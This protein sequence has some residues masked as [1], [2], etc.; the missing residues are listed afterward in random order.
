MSR[1]AAA[2]LVDALRHPDPALPANAIRSTAFDHPSDSSQVITSWKVAEH[3]YRSHTTLLPTLARGLFTTGEPGKEIIVGRGYDKFFNVDE[4]AYT[5]VRL[6]FPSPTLRFSS[7]HVAAWE[8][9]C[10]PQ[11]I[12]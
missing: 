6:P 7:S 1:T 11:P 5:S 4:V 3:L 8:L 2:A 10:W 12:S 9:T